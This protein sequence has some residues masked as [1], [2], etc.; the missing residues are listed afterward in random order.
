MVDTQRPRFLQTTAAS[1]QDEDVMN[2]AMKGNPR[3]TAS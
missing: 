2:F 1:E 3:G